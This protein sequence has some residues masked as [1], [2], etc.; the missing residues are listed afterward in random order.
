MIPGEP[1]WHRSTRVLFAVAFFL[2]WLE[3]VA[4]F[5]Y[6]RVLSRSATPVPT[7]E[8]SAAIVNHSHVFYVAA[9][10]KH[11]YN[12]LL[13]TMGISISAIMLTGFLLHYCIGVKI[14][15]NR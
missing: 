9:R 10:Q 11:L 12:L 15:R 2:V 3:A 8:F 1:R 7:P 14:F 13:V 4:C 5:A 6:F